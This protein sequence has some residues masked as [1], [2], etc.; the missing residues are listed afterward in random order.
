MSYLTLEAKF[1]GK[2][3]ICPRFH[4]LHMPRNAIKASLPH[5]CAITSVLITVL[6]QS[7]ECFNDI[8]PLLI[9]NAVIDLDAP[10]NAIGM[11]SI[12]TIRKCAIRK[13]RNV[14]KLCIELTHASGVYRALVNVD[15]YDGLSAPAITLL[16]GFHEVMAVENVAI[17]RI[18]F[19]ANFVDKLSLRDICPFL[20][21]HLVTELAHELDISRLSLEAFVVEMAENVCHDGCL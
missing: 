4:S 8:G 11:K 7:G 17:K 14:A 13:P 19:L 2:L 21:N 10:K 6:S 9:F 12:L 18:T 20:L 16:A 1:F 3:G 15:S 5:T